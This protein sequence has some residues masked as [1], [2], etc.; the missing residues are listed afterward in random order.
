MA[1]KDNSPISQHKNFAFNFFHFLLQSTYKQKKRGKVFSIRY[2]YTFIA[3]HIMTIKKKTDFLRFKGDGTD[4][5][6][7]DRRDVSY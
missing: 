3:C 7:A 5:R 6:Q 2:K 4:R 1:I